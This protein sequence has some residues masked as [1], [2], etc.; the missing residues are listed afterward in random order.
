MSSEDKKQFNDNC[1]ILPNTIGFLVNESKKKPFINIMQQEF[2]K[3]LLN[4]L[5]S[6][7][8][9]WH[10]LKYDYKLWH[11]EGRC[12]IQT[13]NPSDK[14]KHGIGGDKY[15]CGFFFQ[16]GACKFDTNIQNL[17]KYPILPIDGIVKSDH[18]IKK[19]YLRITLNR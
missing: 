2:L 5:Q 16:G 4:L 12:V 11:F 6:P 13:F 7:E 15:T 3:P 10:I 1:S 9:L 19:F 14:H 8:K 17:Y 18:Y